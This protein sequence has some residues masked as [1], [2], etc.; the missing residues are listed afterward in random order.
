MEACLCCKAFGLEQCPLRTSL[1]LWL[2]VQCYLAGSYALCLTLLGLLVGLRLGVVW[3]RCL[4]LSQHVGRLCHQAASYLG[5]LCDQSL[6]QAD[7]TYDYDDD[8]DDDEQQQQ[9]LGREISFFR[10]TPGIA[11][12]NVSRLI[13]ISLLAFKV[14]EY[15]F[16]LN[17]THW[18]TLF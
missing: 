13:V 18:G 15:C 7:I 10:E 11:G 9:H 2:V 17:V 8:D 4:P 16:I 5:H 1:S 3:F 14:M 6:P 12:E